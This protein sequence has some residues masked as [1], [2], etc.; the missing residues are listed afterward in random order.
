MATKNTKRR[1]KQAQQ[2]RAAFLFV[3][4]VS[5]VAIAATWLSV[6]TLFAAE[7]GVVRLTTDGHLKQRPAWSP[8]GAW[9]AFTRHQGSEIFLFL[10]AVETGQEKRLTAGKDPEMDA[11]WSPDGKRLA[12]TFDKTVPNQGDL[13]IH[14]VSADGDD[15]R[16]AL[17][18]PGKLSQE[19][20]PSWSPDGRWL[21]ITSTR[22]GNQEIYAVRPD[23]QDL[24]RL[25]SDPAIDAHPAWSP[26]GKRIAFATSRWGDLELAV[27][28]ADGS[29]MVRL[30]H[31]VGLDDYPAWSPDG[32]RL[33]FAS[34]REGNLE[35]FACAADGTDL[36]N[37]TGHR[38]I[39]NFP[40][41][42]PAGDLTF[43]SSRAGGFDLYT[44]RLAQRRTSDSP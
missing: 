32:L 8:D 14:T 40:A 9:L 34:N 17:V 44:L 26:D 16:P 42:T 31:S 10:R 43:V 15:Q 41:W 4:V 28:D 7:S 13:D 19:E 29:N 39:D 2:Q 3:F 12:F 33:A 5:F 6:A 37:M 36:Q 22:D 27:M 24:R 1:Q 23:G 30:T 38:A 21:A 25:T 20:W 35:I 11:A 18:S